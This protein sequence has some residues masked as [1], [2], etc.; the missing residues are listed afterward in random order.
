MKTFILCQDLTAFLRRIQSTG[1]LASLK[2]FYFKLSGFCPYEINGT[3]L[4]L[5]FLLQRKAS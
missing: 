4:S 5:V 1:Q 2:Y 3:Y